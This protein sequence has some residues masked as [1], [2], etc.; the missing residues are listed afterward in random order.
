YNFFA[1]NKISKSTFCVTLY[2]A[3]IRWPPSRLTH[4][5]GGGSFHCG[6]FRPWQSTTSHLGLSFHT[7][8]FIFDLFSYILQGRV[9]KLFDR[10]S[11]TAYA[12]LPNDQHR[13]QFLKKA[14]GQ[15]LHTLPC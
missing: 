14:I 4:G 2:N 6:N 15:F 3:T 10:F 12:I 13:R 11:K 1:N 9:Y 5:S 7:L 8:L